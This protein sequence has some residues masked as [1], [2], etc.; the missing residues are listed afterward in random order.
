MQSTIFPT[1][2]EVL[3]LHT[4]LVERFGGMKGVRDLGLVESALMRPRSGYYAT[5]SEQAA[6]LLQSFATNHAFVDGNKR[7]AFAVMVVF[8]ELNGCILCVSTDEAES[9]LIDDVIK[10]HVDIQAIAKWIERF[11]HLGSQAR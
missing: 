8:L 7:I 11:S 3:F 5:L 6:A 1:L 9:F 10:R 2:E 4:R